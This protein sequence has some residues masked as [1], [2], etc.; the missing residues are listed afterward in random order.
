MH[1]LPPNTIL[2]SALAVPRWASEDQNALPQDFPKGCAWEAPGKGIPVLCGL[3]WAR[4]RLRAQDALLTFV[5]NN[6][7]KSPFQLNK[8]NACSANSKKN[9]PSASSLLPLGGPHASPSGFP[10]DLLGKPLGEG[11]LPLG[12]GTAWKRTLEYLS[13]HAAFVCKGTPSSTK[14]NTL[15]YIFQVICS[16]RVLVMRA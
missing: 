5:Q 14:G 4:A 11:Y 12:A 9:L 6:M 15:Q 8:G 10:R 16:Y 1:H 7:F 3:P 13:V 2:R